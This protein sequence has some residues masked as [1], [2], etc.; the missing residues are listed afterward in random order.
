MDHAATTKLLPQAESFMRQFEKDEYAN[1]SGNYSFASKA[2]SA[3]ENSRQIIADSINAEAE[4]I[5]FTSGGTESDNWALKSIFY[6]NQ[7][8]QPHIITSQIEHPAILNTCH[9]LEEKGCQISYVPVDENGT[10]RLDILEKQF[11]KNTILCSVMTAN[12]EI[13]T[14][15]PVEKIAEI[16]HRH[17]ALFHTDAVQAYGH[18]TIDVKKQHIDL[19]SASAH[20]L[21]GPKGCGFLYINKNAKYNPYIHGGGQEHKMRSGTENVAAIAGFGIAAQYNHRNMS[22]NHRKELYLQKYFTEKI[23]REVPDVKINGNSENKLANN[24]SCTLKNVDAASLLELLNMENICIS[25]G[26]ACHTQNPEPSHVLL[27]IEKTK[28]E[29]YNTI[30][31]TIGPENTTKEIDYVVNKIN[32]FAENLRKR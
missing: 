31:V 28:K 7:A 25:A 23:M 24:I 22:N 8:H 14:I 12:N 2:K 17:N 27:A 13:G 16:A 3:I 18:I 10:I 21:N 20:K 19:M 11:R 1:P 15:Q 32:I 6:A 4:E 29:T 30:R 5:Y 9:F 26:S